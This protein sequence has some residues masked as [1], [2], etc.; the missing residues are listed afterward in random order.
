MEELKVIDR[1]TQEE[2]AVA[3]VDTSTNAIV[4]MAM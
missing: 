1:R 4:M 3:P 2:T